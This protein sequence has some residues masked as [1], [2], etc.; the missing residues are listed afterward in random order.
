MLKFIEVFFLGL[1]KAVEFIVYKLFEILLQ[2][3]RVV[4]EVLVKCYVE[5]GKTQIP[6]L[7]LGMNQLALS[8]N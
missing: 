2:F 5:Y 4:P 8:G 3:R 6:Y 7:T 1:W